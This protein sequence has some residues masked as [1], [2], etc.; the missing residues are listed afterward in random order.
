MRR[1]HL[2]GVLVGVG[3]GAGS[4]A[5]GEPL[6]LVGE[7]RLASGAEVTGLCE[8]LAPLG[9]DDDRARREERD[10][11]LAGVY[12][13]TLPSSAFQFKA[14]DGG[15]ARL[16]IDVDRGFRAA[17]G[18][19]ELVAPGVAHAPAPLALDLAVPSNP[20]EAAALV[21]ARK[22]GE[23]TLTVWFRPRGAAA[24][25]TPC[26]TVHARGEKGTRL[27][28][29]PLAFTLAR[30]DDVLATGETEAFQGLRDQA[31]PAAG[32]PHVVVARP[33]LTGARGAAPDAVARAAAALEPELLSCYAKGL[34]GE[35][36]LAG[37]LVL[38]VAVDVE[39]R[40]TEARAELDGLGAPAVTT[41]V[42]SRLRG[43]RFPRG[44][45]ARF[46]VPVK[47]SN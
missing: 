10:Q 29:E 34:A 5:A 23:L 13:M 16:E 19:F 18:S 7:V 38:G 6:G 39:G 33:V 21:K 41:C 44:G 40:V 26:A 11:A 12:V 32:E 46:S 35:P 28:I 22:A 24:G 14:Y 47:F 27:A 30:K 25:E 43:A 15:R 1:I 2:L 36:G 9:E 8:E 45:L 37:T 17:T 20:R 4:A 42:V 3:A 31:A